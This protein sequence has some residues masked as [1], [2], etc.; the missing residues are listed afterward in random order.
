MDVLGF[1]EALM[2]SWTIYPVLF[3][4]SCIDALI[5]VLPSE[6]P[7]ILAGVYAASTGVPIP[8]LVVLCA[9][10]GAC[11]GDHLT[12]AIGRMF[13]DRV[14]RVSTDTRRGRVLAVTRRLI[15]SRGPSALLVGRFIPWGRIAVN[16]LMGASGTPLRRY[17]PYDVVGVLIWA[18]YGLSL[19]YL[20]G[21]AF[22]RNAVAGVLL[23]LGIAL[24][25]TAVIEVGRATWARRQR[26]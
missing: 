11:T 13:A 17:S 26:A 3:G 23:G 10:A 12:Y 24:A 7:I 18:V 14:A 16:L 6:A 2:D 19:G 15:H 4:L 25:V 20:G 21:A 1:V 22:E 9:A 5:P 8:A